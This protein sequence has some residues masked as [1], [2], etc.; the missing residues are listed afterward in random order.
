MLHEHIDFFKTAFVQQHGDT[1]AGRIFAFLVLR[2]DSLLSSA[3]T[4]LFT[5]S[6]K[7][8][9]FFKLITHCILIYC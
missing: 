1:F 9:Y 3:Q 2:L 8:F 4:R 7:L 6:D 5:Q